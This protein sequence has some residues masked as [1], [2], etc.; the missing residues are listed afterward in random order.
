MWIQV[1]SFDGRTSLQVDDLSKLTKIEDLRLRLV[2]KFE[3]PPE[4]QRLFYRGKQLEDG[5]TLF[6]YSVGLNDLVQLMVRAADVKPIEDEEKKVNGYASSDNE[7]SKSDKENQRPEPVDKITEKAGD[8][9]D[10][11]TYKV[12]DVIDA[13]DFS[14]GAWF[15]A[16]LVKVVKEDNPKIKDENSNDSGV[17]SMETDSQDKTKAIKERHNIDN[18]PSD[19]FVYHVV[20]EGYDD[21]DPE[22]LMCK[23]LRPRARTNVPFKEINEGQKVMANFNVDDPEQRGFW[24]DCIITKKQDTRTIKDL[25]ATVFIGPDL[26]PLDDCKLLFV[27]EIFDVEMPGTQLNEYDT[28]VEQ[29]ASPVKRKN[30]PDCD[31]CLDNPRKKCKHCAC[32]EC[33][34]KQDPDKQILCDE[35][36]QAYHLACLKPPLTSIPEDDE[37]YCPDCKTDTN[38]IVKAGEKLKESKKKSKMASQQNKNTTRDWGKGMACVGR[39]K[40]CSVVPPNHFGPIP[41]IEVGTLWK[42]RV[43]VSEAGVHRPHVAGIHGREDEGSYSIVLSG[44]YEDDKDDGDEFTYTGS[45]GRDL[46]GNKRTAEQ[47]CDQQL[48]RMNKALAKN[49]NAPIDAKNG[50]CAENWKGGKPTR[51]IRNCKGRK[52]SKYAPEEGNRYDGIYKI[53]KYWPEKGKSGFLV[54]RYLLRRDDPNPAP[55]TKA[56]KK[57]IDQLGLAMQYPDGYLEAQAK[58]EE[59]AEN[60]AK[61]GTKS[62]KKGKRKRDENDSSPSVSPEKKKKIVGYKIDSEQLQLIKEDVDNKNVWEEAQKFTKEGGQKFLQKVEEL[63]TCICCQEIVFKPVTTE[64][65]HNI[66]KPCLVRSFKA[67]VFNCPMCRADLGKNNNP[68]MNKTLSQIL[69]KFYPGYDN[70]R[71]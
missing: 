5:H 45:G 28:P 6:D 55:W 49:V 30:K 31:H 61:N 11:S 34:G 15:E 40:V 22:K 18:T 70:G 12:G 66:C 4:R 21:N 3:A 25:F 33:G 57:K 41:G 67:E 64:C 23:D 14:V 39:Q 43:Q 37:W 65:K 9:T 51:V 20:F 60:N 19:G 46:S 68:P 54:W 27:N 53:V 17:D 69:L 71:S 47:S 62:T 50:S 44:G 16:K 56:G 36:D 38:A 58:K 48:T 29:S 13:R 42:F 1:R 32:C 8:N 35:C 52:H 59:E 24:Y 2:E 63:F 26:M 7:S 10:A